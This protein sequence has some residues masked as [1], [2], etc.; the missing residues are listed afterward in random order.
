MSCDFKI[1]IKVMVEL[2]K[3]LIEKHTFK[4]RIFIEE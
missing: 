3:R 4:C 2:K 1:E